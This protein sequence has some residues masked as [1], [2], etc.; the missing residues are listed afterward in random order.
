MKSPH[1][2]SA[3]T[4]VTG[5]S[6]Y[7]DDRPFLAGELHV[8]IVFSEVAH[9]RLLAVDSSEA[10]KVPGVVAVYTA[11]DFDHLMWGTIFQDQ[12]LLAKDEIQY[13]GEAI[14]L[15]AAEN[16]EALA[17][18]RKKIRIK[19]EVLPPVLSIRE[20][21]DRKM[22]IGS[23]RT[24]ARGDAEGA[25]KWARHRISGTLEIQGADH[26]Y[27]ESHAAQAIPLDNGAIEVHSSAQHPTEVQH[28]VAHGLGMQSKDVICI[29]KRMGGGF[30]GKESQSAPIAAYAAL[31]ARRL[32]RPARVILNKDDDMIMTG[33][34]N[35]FLIDYEVGFDDQGMIQALNVQ[36]FSDGGAYA[37]LSTSIMER[38]M[39]HSDNAYFIPNAK[40]QGTVC[41]THMHPH[42]AF[43][44]FGGP[45][46][47]AMIERAMEQI[48]DYLKIDAY[49]VRRRN[50]YEGDRNVT[51]YGQ[52]VENN[53]LPE[54]FDRLE[55]S[56]RYRE[57]RQ[58]I[59]AHNQK[60]LSGRFKGQD[61]GLLRGMSMT[62][63]KFGISF[64]TRFLNQGNALVIVYRDGS[65][66]IS[67]GATE[68]GQGVN[69]RI[70]MLVQEIL[71]LPEN[72]VRVMP[73]ATDK[74]ANTS[75]TAASSGTDLN[76]SAAVIAAKK[77]RE[78]LAVVARFCENLPR[79]RWASKTAGLGTEKEAQIQ[80]PEPHSDAK[81]DENRDYIFKDGKVTSRK[82]PSWS[83]SFSELTNEA[84]LNRVSLSDYGHYRI[85]GLDFN[86]LTGQGRA[87]MYYTNGTC[88]TEVSVDPLTGEVKVLRTDLL[89]D[90][91]RPI[92]EGLDLGQVTGAYIQGL[93]WVTTENLFYS[94]DGKLLSHS[95]STYKIPSVQDIPRI[96][97]VELLPNLGNTTNVRGTK[98]V[99]EPPLLLCLSAWTA[100]GDAVRQ[101]NGKPYPNI[102]IPAT[103]ER[104]LRALKPEEFAAWEGGNA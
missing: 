62:A 2:D 1:L 20:A 10:L 63:V 6:E 23:T 59:Q 27:L 8:G 52:T 35:P 69:T 37:D 100:I 50:C 101:G 39:L 48:A 17:L 46:G 60:V 5:L 33:K 75:P 34:R 89:M 91:G 67:T 12:P 9:A 58:E 24:I 53:V 66:A 3:P 40:I 16:K 43:R 7:I 21:R 56:S 38:A 13:V 47:V 81:V 61:S 64:T 32:N 80:F 79:D 85:E 102:K 97:N 14:C 31:V 84:Y 72:Q 96:F 55:K 104:V 45:K 29:V 94:K 44:G 95:P 41:K 88:V 15:V 99:G 57:R 68:M 78:R 74:N 87:F 54:L 77:I 26:F 103:S 22:F 65:C 51:P 36:H 25:M 76:G 98:A 86:K 71:G 92:N 93:G 4:H 83:I 18:G 73:T 11:N 82:N 70:R 42:T 49:D 30:G 90:L 19:T 28:V